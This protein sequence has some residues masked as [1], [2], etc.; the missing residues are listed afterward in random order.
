MEGLII[1][2]NRSPINF[3]KEGEKPRLGIGGL[4]QAMS[5]LLKDG[6][7]SWVGLAGGEYDFQ[8]CDSEHRIEYKDDVYHFHMKKVFLSQRAIKR[9]YFNFCNS[10]L[11]PLFHL[12]YPKILRSK[13]FPVPEYS[14]RDFG[15]Y[16][17]ANTTFANAVIEEYLHEKRPIWVQDYH[18]L[19]LPEKV[20]G[21]L[22]RRLGEKVA[23][24]QF[25]HIPFFSPDVLRKTKRLK[26]KKRELRE[27]WKE[28]LPGMLANDLLG[29][30]VPEYVENFVSAVEHY[31]P[32]A[33]IKAEKDLYRV[34]FH[35]KRC[36]IGSFP[37][38]IDLERFEKR[39]LEEDI[40]YKKPDFD[41]KKVIERRKKKGIKIYAGVDRLD[42]TKGILERLEILETLLDLGERLQYIGFSPR[43]RTEAKG[44]R[45]LQKKASEKV[46][47]INRR[48]KPK[49]GY[50]PVI[51]RV[52]HI[53]FPENYKLLRDADVVMV[54][55][56]EDGMNLVAFEAIYSKKY[57]PEEGRGKLVLGRCGASKLLEDYGREDGIIRIDPFRKK[58]SAKRISKP[59][60]NI[61]DRLIDFVEREVDVNKWCKKFLETLYEVG[62]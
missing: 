57:R 29:F 12:T 36:W 15:F 16:E 53:P 48:F 51:Y 7:T 35:N 59:S 27:V 32:K 6:K 58:E 9:Y 39:V 37:I 61:S 45:E 52:E 1:V 23:L 17:M 60:G 56:L 30:H 42:Y 62:K 50:E 13:G 20:K 19:L 14:S 11:W 25:I 10:Y 46:K 22:K 18:F 38:G 33:R 24:G 4:V 54:T 40:S 26:G 8:K 5:G 34:D 21:M 3:E 2:A 43:S 47:E 31:L 49:L 55:S 41:L 28:I 44:Y